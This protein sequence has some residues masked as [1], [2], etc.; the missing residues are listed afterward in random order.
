MSLRENCRRLLLLAAKG[1]VCV[2]LLSACPSPVL[3]EAPIRQVSPFFGCGAQGQQCCRAP[4]SSQNLPAFGPLVACQQGLG[5]DITTNLC[6]SSCGGTGQACCDGPETRALKWTEDGKVYSPNYWN[7]R[8]MCDGGACN[9]QTHRCF[10]CGTQDGG[11]CCPPDAAQATARCVGDNLKCQFD[12]NVFA[13]SGI[14]VACGKSG[15][16]PCPWG[17]E[18]GL[19]VLKG[20]C[21]VCG[22]DGQLPC[23]KG[24]NPGLGTAAQGLCR[25]CGA[26]GQIPCDFGCRS[27][28]GVKGNLCVACGGAGQA[29]CDAGCKP[30]TRLINNICT[31][32][33]GLNQ[34]PCAQG[35]NYPLKVAGN[36]CRFCGGNGQVPCDVGCDQGL[37]V[38]GGLCKPPGSSSPPMCATA[39][40]SCVADFVSGTHCCQS[41]GPLLCVY[42][43][44]RACILHGQ[45]VPPGGTQICCSKKDGDE[46]KF[47]QATGKTICDIPG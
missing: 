23:D 9:R 38:S 28:L 34:P 12:S 33:G 18:P 44:C 3:V 1:F 35:C 14:C 45:E 47:D 7:V 20:L 46:P 25:A 32:C 39:T 24:C 43:Q 42:S 40:Q 36:V 19:D 26:S 21:A 27:G 30:G 8:E 37:V 41:G 10:A 16:K 4:A 11:A 29:P 15:R 2:S 17:C 5:C 13:T 6:V 31:S 22:A